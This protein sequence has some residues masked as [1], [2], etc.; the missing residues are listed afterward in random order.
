MENIRV[1]FTPSTK[2]DDI[3]Q[4]KIIRVREFGA[5]ALFYWLAQKLEL[6]DLINLCVPQAL[7]GRRT[8]LT[9]GHYLILSA[10]NRAIYPQSK[11]ALAEWYR[12]TVLNSL[13]P[14]PV[15]N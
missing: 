7:P 9:A 11:Q 8:S 13:L 2:K 4:L 12:S 1:Q 15:K 6:I 14:T 10:I 5:S 3:P